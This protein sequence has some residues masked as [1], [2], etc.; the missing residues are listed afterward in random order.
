MSTSVAVI[1]VNWNS[2]SQ[3]RHCIDSILRF[4]G[5][6]SV[7]IIVVDNGSTDGSAA[8]LDSYPSVKLVRAGV[9]LGFA[10][11][12]NLGAEQAANVD[13]LLF[14]NPDAALMYRTLETAIDFMDRPGSAG[15]GICGVAMVDEHGKLWRSC[16]RF[17]TPRRLA[18]MSVGLDRLLPSVGTVMADWDHSDSRSVEQV[19]GAFFLVRS[20]LF[21]RLNGFDE[22][23]FMYFE[24]VDF[25]LRAAAVGA[26][27]IYIAES[28]AFHAGGGTSNQVRARRIFYSLRSRL[29][30]ARKNFSP[31]GLTSV[32]ISTLLLEP[33]FRCGL[34][35][36][37][38]SSAGVVETMS[39]YRMLIVWLLVSKKR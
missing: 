3:I 2:G 16:S 4:R 38:R 17:P 24:E 21:K 11:A 10:K 15:F 5:F 13:Y 30:Y 34:Q 33:I 23:F 20:D 9:N 19:I 35:L 22:R 32:A 25:S 12:C 18:C 37:K 39:A 36:L 26:R 14:L 29:L 31:L 8:E 1:I 27:T 28:P 7:S 6:V